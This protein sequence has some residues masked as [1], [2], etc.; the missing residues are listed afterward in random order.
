MQLWN[1]LDIYYWREVD[2]SYTVSKDIYGARIESKI[3]PLLSLLWHFFYKKPLDTIPEKWYRA[4]SFIR[5][6]FFKVEWFEV[7]D[8]IQV[9]AN[10]DGNVENSKR[11]VKTCN[12]VLEHSLSA[13]RFVD[14]QITRITSE[15]EIQSIEES[16]QTSSGKFDGASTHLRAALTLMADRK[17]PDYRNSI[18]ESMSAVEAICKILAE[19]DNATLG[20]ALKAIENK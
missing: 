16:I 14:G 5:E 1:T 7:Y 12:A 10:R 18:K 2:E 4:Y 9:M 6:Y 11:F 15:E 13:Y 19:D 17:H 20:Q 8:F 3:Y